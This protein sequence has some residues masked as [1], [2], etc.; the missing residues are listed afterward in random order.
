MLGALAL[1]LSWKVSRIIYRTAPYLYPISKKDK[2]G[3]EFVV[4]AGAT[5]GIGLEYLRT[6]SSQYSIVAIGR[7]AAKLSQ[8]KQSYPNIH[9]LQV[10]FAKDAC[11]ESAV[12][13]ASRAISGLAGQ[14]RAKGLINCVGL[15]HFSKY[16]QTSLEA[17]A[18]VNQTNI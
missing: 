8:L 5:D 11:G 17:I 3:E 7:N 4:I 14:L 15:S 18:R 1:P 2:A 16:S 6:L 13:E 10:D 9:T 12:E